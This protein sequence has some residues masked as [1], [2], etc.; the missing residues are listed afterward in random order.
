MDDDGGNLVNKL[1]EIFFENLFSFGL[2]V[3]PVVQ[4]LCNYHD[5][6]HCGMLQIIPSVNG[7]N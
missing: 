6:E 5:T 3:A 4:L 2:F 1:L 7:I